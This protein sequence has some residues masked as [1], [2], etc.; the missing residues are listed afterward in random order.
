MKR[1]KY[2]NFDKLAIFSCVV[3]FLVSLTLSITKGFSS[4]VLIW[5]VLLFVS[6]FLPILRSKALSFF[7]NKIDLWLSKVKAKREGEI[8]RLKECNF[9][10]ERNRDLWLAYG[11]SFCDQPVENTMFNEYIAKQK[12]TGISKF[13]FYINVYFLIPRA[14]SIQ[15]LGII[16]SSGMSLEPWGHSVEYIMYQ[17]KKWDNKLAFLNY[18]NPLWW[19][20]FIISPIFFRSA[21]SYARKQL[22]SV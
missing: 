10:E 22:L 9:K 15:V 18:F 13:Q 3:I 8:E 19:L 5:G 14:F 17:K 21:N 2:N 16:I 12:N 7:W 1:P 20:G 11:E 4:S 6:L